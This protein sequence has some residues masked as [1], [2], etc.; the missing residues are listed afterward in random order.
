MDPTMADPQP[1]CITLVFDLASLLDLVLFIGAIGVPA[2][3]IPYIAR[4]ARRNP[5]A[6]LRMAGRRPA[7][8]IIFR[9]GLGVTFLGI[10]GF[11]GWL[12]AG[13]SS[14]ALCAN[15]L[16]GVTLPVI[17][18]VLIFVGALIIGGGWALA[19]RAVWVVLATL[20]LLDWWI[21]LINLIGLD[22]GEEG[23]GL[24]LLAFAIHALC[25]C[26][27]ARWMFNARD[28][29]P[30]ERSKAGEAGRSLSAVWV[31]LASYA[32][33]AMVRSESGIFQSAAGSAVTGALTVG[34]LAVTMGSG[35][36]KYAE[37]INAKKPA[38]AVGSAVPMGSTP[39]P[40]QQPTAEPVGSAV[41]TTSTPSPARPR[42]SRSTPPVSPKPRRHRP[43]R[44]SY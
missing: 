4:V 5:S 12:I 6:E 23:N 42:R 10:V 13:M 43:H 34:A 39:S 27:A 20:A 29:G 22:A 15:E 38:P 31:F 26:V 3:A 16:T 30:V 21:F 14:P 40:S 8:V 33:L 18:L 35:F 19:I 7:G 17:T 44:G 2:V 25:S 41:A 28:L 24:L 37:A 11:T 9:W 32:A 36:T 1:V